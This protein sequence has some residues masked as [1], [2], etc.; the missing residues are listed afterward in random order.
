MLGPKLDKEREKTNADLIKLFEQR[1]F[2]T[3]N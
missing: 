3:Y 2:L 1:E